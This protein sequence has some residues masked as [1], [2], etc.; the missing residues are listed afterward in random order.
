MRRS[1]LGLTLIELMVTLTIFA[2]LG[3]FAVPGMQAIFQRGH[4]D[5]GTVAERLSKDFSLAYA[6]SLTR[7]SSLADDEGIFLC[8]VSPDDENE[9]REET[10]VGRWEGGWL[11]AVTSLKGDKIAAGNILERYKLPDGITINGDPS[12]NVGRYGYG[13]GKPLPTSVVTPFTLRV[14]GGISSFNVIFSAYGSAQVT[15]ASATC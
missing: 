12:H 9:C 5:A 15:E 8:P 13:R 2:I 14:C 6:R 7:G 1:L 3:A 11:M 10:N 4:S